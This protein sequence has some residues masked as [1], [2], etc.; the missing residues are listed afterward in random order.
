MLLFLPLILL[1]ASLVYR[2]HLDR[3]RGDIAYARSRRAGQVAAKRLRK[4]KKYLNENT[5]K[6]FYA[7]VSRA[8]LGFLGDKLNLAEAGIITDQVEE[9]L[10]GRGVDDGVISHYINCLKTCDYQRFAPSDSK[11]NQMRKLFQDSK[12]AIIELEKEL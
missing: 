7:E 8:L 10:R 6:E 5:Q 4:A 1:G 11:I 9:M 12:R 3:L 2:R